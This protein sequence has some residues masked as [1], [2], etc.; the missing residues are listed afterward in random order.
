MPPTSRPAGPPPPGRRP[1][2]RR[3]RARRDHLVVCGSDSL[4]FRLVE[5]LTVRY[6]ERVTVTLPAAGRGYGPQLARLPGVRIIERAEPDRQ[7]LLEADL[8]GGGGPGP[9][10]P[11]G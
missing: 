1:P 4:A 9:L 3:P 10:G 8:G 6:G 2:G 7:A 11:A 5:G